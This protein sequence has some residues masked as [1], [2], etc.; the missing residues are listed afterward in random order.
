MANIE[1]PHETLMFAAV[2]YHQKFVKISREDYEG[3]PDFGEIYVTTERGSSI[4]DKGPSKDVSNLGADISEERIQKRAPREHSDGSDLGGESASSSASAK[5]EPSESVAGMV[6]RTDPPIQ[7]AKTRSGSK[8]QKTSSKRSKSKVPTRRFFIQKDLL[9]YRDPNGHERLC[10]PDNK[11]HDGEST[12]RHRLVKEIHDNA[13]AIHLGVARTTMEL[14]KRVYWPNMQAFVRE[15]IAKCEVCQRNK[16]D[17]RWP[18]G[19]GVPLQTD[20]CLMHGCCCCVC[21]LR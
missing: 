15:Y 20:Q 4:V 21:C 1:Q 19:K 12:L 10:V 13:M 8:D 11:S 3:C 14:S 16:G 18:M 5:G 17:H 9:Y 2:R 7:P 6:Q